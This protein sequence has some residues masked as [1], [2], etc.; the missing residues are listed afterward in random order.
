MMTRMLK[1]A[2]PTIVPTPRSPFVMN[3]P[4]MKRQLLID[5]T[6]VLQKT[7]LEVTDTDQSKM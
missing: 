1:T 7:W 5:S 6:N 2:D 3:T 4:D